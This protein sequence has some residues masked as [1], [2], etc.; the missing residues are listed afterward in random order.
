MRNRLIG[1]I[2]VTAAAALLS[3]VVAGQGGQPPSAGQ[4]GGRGRGAPAGP[5]EPTPRLSDGTPNLGRVPGEKGIW[6]VPYITNMGVRVLGPDGN[7]AV[8]PATSGR[9]G[10]ANAQT[11][12]AA[13]S[14]QPLGGGEGTGDGGRGGARSEP[15]VPFQPWA[16]AVYDYNS[17]N[18]SK[19][20]PEGYCLPPGGPRLMATPYPMEIVQLPEQKRILMVF[21]GATH[22]WREIYMDGRPHPQGDALNPTYLGHS[23]GHW[24]GDSLVVDVVGFNEATWLDYFGHPHTDMLH[25][26][27]R[28]TRPNK[29]TLHYEALV[30]DPGAYTKPF[31][32]SWDIPWRANAELT[33]YICQENN[34]YLQRLTDD[35]GEP[36]FGKK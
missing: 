23:V 5:P 3:V 30:D 33:E 27:E 11:P 6:Y 21:E 13:G 10:G 15:Q 7:L 19:Y 17:K 36:V 34:K 24:E 9:R 32:L 26:V 29:N 35:F 8:A 28:F 25:V 1:A 22:I 12:I 16:A 18:L 20:D 31:T 2:A 4:A 14:N